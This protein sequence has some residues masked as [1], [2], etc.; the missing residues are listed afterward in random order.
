[1]SVGI[2][3]NIKAVQEG[4]VCMCVRVCVCACMCARV[5]MH[6]HHQKMVVLIA[7]IQNTTVSL[8]GRIRP[9]RLQHLH[10]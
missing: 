5:Y 8:R 7:Q 2:H 6:K 1:M 10:A 9:E 3:N 4:R